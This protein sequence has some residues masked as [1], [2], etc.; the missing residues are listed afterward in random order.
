MRIKFWHHATFDALWVI[1][2][3]VHVVMMMLEND[4]GV[5]LALD[6]LSPLLCIE[7]LHN[8]HVA[9]FASLLEQSSGCG[10]ILEWSNDFNN[11]AT[12]RDYPASVNHVGRS[13]RLILTKEVLEAPLCYRRVSEAD[14]DSQHFGLRN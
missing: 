1:L 7:V 12:N 3:A 6:V 14:F 10:V 4:L 5:L 9:A 11:V 13:H 2:N 8:D